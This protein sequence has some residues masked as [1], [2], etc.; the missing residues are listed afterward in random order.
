[1]TTYFESFGGKAAVK[2]AMS[3]DGEKSPDKA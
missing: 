3:F 1:M 2:E